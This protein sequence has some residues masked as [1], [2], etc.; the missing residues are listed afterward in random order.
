MR[1]AAF[2]LGILLIPHAAFAAWTAT[3]TFESYANG[4]N[5][6][7]LNGGSNWATAYAYTPTGS[8]TATITNST[9]YDGSLAGQIVCPSG[10]GNE[11]QVKRTFTGI[12]VGTFQVAMRRNTSSADGSKVRISS[13]GVANYCD[14]DFNNDGTVTMT[15]ASTQS[16]GNY[17]ANTWYVVTI[18]FDTGANTCRAKID[19]G[20]YSTA[21]GWGG[22]GGGTISEIYFRDVA[23]SN[24]ARTDFFD[25][26]SVPAAGAATF[27][28]NF[29]WL[30][31]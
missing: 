19:S 9:A 10:V 24:G 25:A 8:C 22:G 11:G 16:V 20:S 26:V 15:G 30:F 1:Y 6:N 14:L 2:L 18:D 3:D 5:W 17:S 12:T 23:T 28:S 21:V 13:S 27:S 31:F 7:T 4:N 29:W